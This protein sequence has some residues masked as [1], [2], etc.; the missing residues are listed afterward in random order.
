[1]AFETLNLILSTALSI[2]FMQC[3]KIVLM[4]YND[5]IKA[6]LMALYYVINFNKQ[7]IYG[8]SN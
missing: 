8:K 2:T 6:V 3:C 5:R 7:N 4:F 1:M